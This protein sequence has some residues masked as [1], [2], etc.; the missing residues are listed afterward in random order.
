MPIDDF[1]IYPCKAVLKMELREECLSSAIKDFRGNKKID[2]VFAFVDSP[3]TK[4]NFRK[5]IQMQ[6]SFAEHFTSFTSVPHHMVAA[7]MPTNTLLPNWEMFLLAKY[8]SFTKKTAQH[9]AFFRNLR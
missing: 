2:E 6:S 3:E 9:I 7:Q 5:F 4:K 8:F 1:E